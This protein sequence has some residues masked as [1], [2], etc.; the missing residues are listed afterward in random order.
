MPLLTL[1]TFLPILGGLALMA[2]PNRSARVAH[3][4]S[5]LVTGVVFLLTLMIWSR[6]IIAGGFAQ[7]EELAWIPA[8]G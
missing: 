8:I 2:L 4:M 1:A 6:G 5:I 7:I 3:G